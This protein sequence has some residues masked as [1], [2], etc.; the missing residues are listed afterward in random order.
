[1]LA[2]YVSFELGARLTPLLFT[3]ENPVAPIDPVHQGRL[4]DGRQPKEAA[5]AHLRPGTRK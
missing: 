1:M 2:Y 5:D 3:D 4:S